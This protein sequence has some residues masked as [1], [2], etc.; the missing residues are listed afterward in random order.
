MYA[1][2]MGTK[3]DFAQ[4]AHWYREAAAQGHAKAQFNLGFLHSHGQGVDQDYAKAYEWYA[5]SEASGY[6]IAKQNRDYIARKLT[7]E[8]RELAQW[9]ADSFRH[10]AGVEA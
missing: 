7:P 10:R 4:A 2:G 5:I 1:Q 6:A 3:Q 8:E 9:R